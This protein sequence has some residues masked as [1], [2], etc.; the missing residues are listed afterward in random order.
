[1]PSHVRGSLKGFHLD[2]RFPA[3]PFAKEPV[4]GASPRA[5]YSGACMHALGKHTHAIEGDCNQFD[6]RMRTNIC[7]PPLQVHRNPCAHSTARI[8]MERFPRRREQADLIGLRRAAAILW[9]PYMS[10]QGTQVL[11]PAHEG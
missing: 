10:C 5:F 7:P 2:K 8:Y 1:M 11:A 6:S 4:E 3:E 9:H